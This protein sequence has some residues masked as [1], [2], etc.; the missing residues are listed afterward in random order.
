MYM[1]RFEIF[2]SSYIMMCVERLSRRKKEI[3]Y[4]EGILKGIKSSKG[5]QPFTGEVGVYGVGDSTRQDLPTKVRAKF[6]LPTN[7]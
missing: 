5:M 7:R 6:H 1:F 2:P 3:P 4:K